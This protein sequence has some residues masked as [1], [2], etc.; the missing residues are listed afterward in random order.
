MIQGHDVICWGGGEFAQHGHQLIRG[1]VSYDKGQLSAPDISGRVKLAACRSSH[2]IVVTVDD[3]I[4][5]W[6][7]NSSGQLGS[8]ESSD[9]QSIV[10]LTLVPPPPDDATVVSVACGYRHTMIVMDNGHV[11]ACGNNFYAQLGYDFRKETYKENQTFPGLLRYLVHN[12]VS[13]VSCGDK[14][15]LFLYRSGAVAAVGQN[16]HGQIGD[17]GRGESVVP[18]LVDLDCR[19]V[20]ISSGSNHN[21]AVVGRYKSC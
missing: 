4:F 10:R 8:R 14:H 21:L 16:E 9:G 11:Y 7:N 18:K 15:T 12:P 3:K 17:G 5:A 13:Q 6:G 19:V 1:D 20:S 2:N